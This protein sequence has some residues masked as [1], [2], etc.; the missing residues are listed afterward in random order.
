MNVKHGFAFD[1]ENITAVENGNILLTPGNFLVGGGWKNGKKY[2]KGEV[3]SDYVLREGD[4]VV[5]MTDLSKEGDTLGYP[6]LLPNNSSKKYL[7]NQR[8]GLVVLKSNVTSKEYIYFLMRFSEYQK[9]IVN[10]ASGSTVR[11]TSPTKIQSF[12]FAI[13]PLP[14]QHAIAA[15]LSSLDKKIGHLRRQ[16]KTLED[17]AQAIFREWFVKFR[18]PGCEKYK[19]VRS[20]IG[21]VPKGWRVAKLTEVV[22]IMSGGTP[23]TDITDY[24]GGEIPFFTPK[25][26]KDQ[27]YVVETE[28]NVTRKGLE[29]CNS[30]LYPKNTVFITARGTVGKCALSAQEMAMNQS[31]Y[32]LKGKFFSNLFIFL[33]IKQVVGNLQGAASG[34]VFDAITVS[35]FE[36]VLVCIPE[37]KLE[38]KF[39]AVVKPLF[40]KMIFNDTNIRSLSIAQN[41]L[42]PKLLSGKIRAKGYSK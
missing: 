24:W 19:M 37:K 2:F 26:A 23:K 6:A 21:K 1:G 8:V 33:L 31:C 5:S 39:S 17:V 4:L 28:K 34:A 14:E 7:H 27:F 32:A 30:K 20:E 13:P 10:T 12:E 36:S 18:F 22:E 16:N 38:E 25:D 3:P 41:L 29:N 35:T 9:Y 42:L 40:E 11:H 15:V